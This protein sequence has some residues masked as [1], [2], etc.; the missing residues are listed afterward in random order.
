MEISFGNSARVLHTRHLGKHYREQI[1]Q[2]LLYS[3][4]VITFDFL[5]VRT[6][7]N[8]FAD[9]CFAKLLLSLELRDLQMRTTFKNVSPLIETVILKAFKER[10]F[11][12]V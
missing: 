11:E 9:E 10:A 8:S 7:T 2:H 12:T 1:E 5:G 3:T 4:D 6:I